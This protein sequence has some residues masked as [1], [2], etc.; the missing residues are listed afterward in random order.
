MLGLILKKRGFTL[1]EVMLTM[2]VIA[3]G[4]FAI[5][6]FYNNAAR[7]VVKGD[8]NLIAG[9]LAREKM[10]WFLM[11]RYEPCLYLS[12]GYNDSALISNTENITYGGYQFTR[13]WVIYLVDPTDLTTQ[14]DGSDYK[15]IN[16]TVSWGPNIEQKVSVSTIITNYP[17]MFAGPCAF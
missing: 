3:G 7:D 10:E 4:L 14:L 11:R 1:I 15:R 6:V 13:S 2:I 8:M 12:N 17:N 5:M 9:Y 16:V